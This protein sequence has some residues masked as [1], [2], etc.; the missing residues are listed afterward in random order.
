MVKI[1]QAL[2]CH[3]PNIGYFSI[4]LNF[5]AIVTMNSLSETYRQVFGPGREQ[6]LAAVLLL[7]AAPFLFTW[8][9]TSAASWLALKTAQKT[10]EGLKRPP[11]LPSYIPILGHTIWF[12]RDA[13]SLLT[14]AA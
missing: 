14:K 11:T 5:T 6:A 8:L 12:L 1:L 13:H 4:F 10:T 9:F 7:A 3:Q 2:L